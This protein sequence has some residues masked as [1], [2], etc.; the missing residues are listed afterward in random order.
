MF[1]HVFVDIFN[2]Y[3]TQA[4]R[5]FSHR[6]VAIG[7]INTF[8]PIIFTLHVLAL[9][10]W[11]MGANPVFT[12]LTTYLIIFFYY[13]LRFAIKAAVKKAVYNTIPDAD[14]V[15]IAPTMRFFQWRVAASTANCH[16]VGRAYGR[17]VNIYDRFERK[18]M[19]VNA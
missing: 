16:Y 14:D 15:F 2:A 18:P 17:S 1:L 13:L 9:S 6:W 19:P 7:V 12:M 8:D 3:G 5:P 11:S 4:L 10:I